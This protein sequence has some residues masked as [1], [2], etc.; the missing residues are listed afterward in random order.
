ML[1]LRC[2]GT[3]VEKSRNKLDKN[4]RL[5]FRRE[6]WARTIDLGV[7]NIYEVIE[8]MGVN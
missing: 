8:V 6:A 4:A 5:E 1:S 7:L 3:P 2:Y